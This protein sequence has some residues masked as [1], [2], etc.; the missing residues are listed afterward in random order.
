MIARRARRQRLLAVAALL[1]PVLLAQ[2]TRH[3]LRGDLSAASAS[4]AA[5]AQPAPQSAAP[6]LSPAQQT[7]LAYVHARSLS[8]RD[9]AYTP[10]LSPMDH[11]P[12]RADEHAPAL[13][14]EPEPAPSVIQRDDPAAQLP[15]GPL[16]LT[17][18]MTAPDEP[19]GALAVI[20]GRVMR[21]GD[22]VEPGWTIHA[23]DR[24]D[25]R[26]RLLG[27]AGQTVSLSRQ[28]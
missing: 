27:P 23:I 20:N 9:A 1:A 3:L 4:T 6:D 8:R 21:V 15:R 26:V 10:I 19:G 14:H 18:V 25:L 13:A 12:A 16:A 22:L 2:A 5:P 28:R 7:A 11:L 17:S 24:S